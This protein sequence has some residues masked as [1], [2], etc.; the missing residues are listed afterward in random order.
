MNIQEDLIAIDGDGVVFDYSGSYRLAW[1][2]AFGV[3]LKDARPNAYWARDRW[4]VPFLADTS[5]LKAAMAELSFWKNMKALEGA[6]EACRILKRAGYRLCCVTALDAEFESDRFENLK[7]LEFEFDDCI[8]TGNMQK[9]GI[10]P[11][12]EVLK[13]LMPAAFVDDFSPFFIG[14]DGNIH[15][16]LIEPGK[17]DSPNTGD[18][19]KHANS[20]HHNLLDFAK[21]WHAK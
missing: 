9:D 18:N 12:A 1:E 8:A 21:Y 6:Q 11:K 17:E 7:S 15:K 14:V 10:S 16:A 19:L 4:N 5:H 20:S 13:K 2:H 3:S